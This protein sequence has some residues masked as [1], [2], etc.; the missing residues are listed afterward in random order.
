MLYDLLCIIPP[1]KIKEETSK[2]KKQI[3]ELIEKKQGKIIKEELLGEK[4]FFFP[5]KRFRKGEYLSFKLEASSEKINEI[6]KELKFNPLILRHLI[7][8]ID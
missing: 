8:K 6:N 3:L 7:V 2:I 4:N 5:I 1:Q